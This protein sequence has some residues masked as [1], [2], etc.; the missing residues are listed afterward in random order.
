MDHETQPGRHWSKDFVE[1]LR[2]IHFSLLLVSVGVVILALVRT[3]SEINRAHDQIKQILDFSKTWDPNFLQHSAPE[4][5]LPS[6][7]SA[8]NAKFNIKVP[9]GVLAPMSLPSR[10][11]ELTTDKTKQTDVFLPSSLDKKLPSL[12]SFQEMWDALHLGADVVD[13]TTVP[14][15]CILIPY[16]AD[17]NGIKVRIS[18]AYPAPC[19]IAESKG[20]EKTYSVSADTSQISVRDEK[21]FVDLGIAD[22]RYAYGYSIVSVN[23]T[24]YRLLLPIDS[25]MIR[26]HFDPQISLI[27]MVPGEWKWHSGAYKDSFRELA[28]ISEEYASIDLSTAERIVAAEE[29]RSA[30]SLEAFGMKFPA[31]TAIR[32]GVGAALILI[33]QLYLWIHL[34]EFRKRLA[35]GDEGWNVAWLGVYETLPA[36]IA[37]YGSLLILPMAGVLAVGIRG[38]VISNFGWYSWLVLTGTSL[39]ST[40]LSVLICATLPKRPEPIAEDRK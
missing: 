4:S 35:A 7:S 10:F 36:R 18:K 31:E 3:Q 11:I 5:S 9:Y 33:V 29:K 32:C 17:G 26:T 12:Q 30:E 8:N 34:F 23:Y 39:A 28:G 25:G 21:T 16:Y 38:L 27:R 6:P 1:H 22:F 14:S 37:L 15:R 40:F 13:V 2:S 20:A 19:K 24:A